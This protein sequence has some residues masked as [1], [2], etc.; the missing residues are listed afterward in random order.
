M[1]VPNPQS[2]G[3]DHQQGTG[4]GHGGALRRLGRAPDA[5]A[6]DVGGQ[7]RPSPDLLGGRSAWTLV[8]AGFLILVGACTDIIAFKASLD[9]FLRGA[10]WQ[11]WLVAVGATALSLLCAAGAG[12]ALEAWRRAER[13]A[14]AG[15]V[16]CFLAWLALGG[17]LFLVRW[18]S[19][20]LE[21]AGGVLV[22][23][24]TR[25]TRIARG[26]VSALFFGALY[27]V[28][29]VVTAFEAA[30]WHDPRFTALR[31][32]SEQTTVQQRRV[33]ELAG[34]CERARHVAGLH[35]RETAREEARRQAARQQ[36]RALGAEAAN[37]ARYLMACLMADPSRTAVTESGPR[38]EEPPATPPFPVPPAAA[39]AGG[40]EPAG[41]ES[42]DTDERAA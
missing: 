31:R 11:S 26:Q 2:P 16:V 28:S 25:R 40:P 30:R 10:E 4:A 39:A 38:I 20:L 3:P 7:G 13:G 17:A 9:L 14:V 23:E 37:Y 1:P 24:A 29:G 41:D 36:R 22:D 19:G 5:D 32:L 21:S 42:P 27:L 18:N 6:A 34:E 8:A 33:A 35:E 15:V 12:L